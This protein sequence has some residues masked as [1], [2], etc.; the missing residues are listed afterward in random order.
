MTCSAKFCMSAPWLPCCLWRLWSFI[1]LGFLHI[2]VMSLAFSKREK[3]LCVCEQLICPAGHSILFL[4]ILVWLK[5]Q[6]KFGAY[7][8][9]FPAT[10]TETECRSTCLCF[11]EIRTCCETWHLVMHPAVLSGLQT[12]QHLLRLPVI[13][14]TQVAEIS[15]LQTFLRSQKFYAFLWPQE[16][17]EYC[18]KSP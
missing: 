5:E 12:E 2:T 15:T 16:N 6:D 8:L 4:T 13:T 11:F 17:L 9:K 1:H 7:Q 3:C 10:S 14:L 18:I